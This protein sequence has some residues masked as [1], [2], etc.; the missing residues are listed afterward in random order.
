MSVTT[1]EKILQL[2][3][4]VLASLCFGLAVD[5]ALSGKSGLAAAHGAVFV[6]NV[7]LIWIGKDKC[8]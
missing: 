1:S 4:A 5:A 6:L 2:F 3:Q 8:Q 7:L